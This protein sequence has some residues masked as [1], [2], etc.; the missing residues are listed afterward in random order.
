MELAGYDLIFEL[1]RDTLEQ[2]IHAAPF[3]IDSDG[4]SIH[5][6]LAP[7]FTLHKPIPIG[8]KK[9]NLVMI[10]TSVSLVAISRSDRAVI[11]LSFEKTYAE[12]PGNFEL[13]MLDGSITINVP[14]VATDPEQDSKHPDINRSFIAFDFSQSDINLTLDPVWEQKLVTIL[15]S[16]GAKELKEKFHDY[17]LTNMI[18][19]QGEVKSSFSFVV[20][21]GID[22]SSPLVLT[23][24]PEIMWIDKNTLGIF[25]YLR[26]NASGGDVT[27]KQTS[28]RDLTQFSS[29]AFLLSPKGFRSSVVCPSIHNMAVDQVKGDTFQQFVDVERNKDKNPGPA[30][31]EE[32]DLAK[33]A[34]EKFFQS[35]QGKDIIKGVTPTPCGN[36]G[37]GKRVKMP[38]PFSDTTAH[39]TFLDVTL[40]NDQLNFSFR[41]DAEVSCAKIEVEMTSSTE[42]S[43]D[44]W[45]RLITS[46]LKKGEPSVHTSADPFCMAA[47]NFLLSYFIGPLFSTIFT[48]L[49][50]T[51][52]ENFADALVRN[53]IGEAVNFEVPTPSIGLDSNKYF[54]MQTIHVSEDGIQINGTM[55]WIGSSKGQY[56]E[57]QIEINVNQILNEPSQTKLPEAKIFHFPGTNY[58]CPPQ[59]F[60]YNVSYWN[61]AFKVDIEAR[62]VA[63][64]IKINHF[65]ATLGHSS[66]NDPRPTFTGGSAVEVTAPITNLSGWVAFQD[67]PLEGRVE[68]RDSLPLQV[69][70]NN[71]E[72]W[73]LK[74]NGEDGRFDV[75]LEVVATD[76]S[77]QVFV[78]NQIVP[79]Y[80][81]VITFG[82]DYQTAMDDCKTKYQ[83]WYTVNRFV[84]V[85][86]IPM[87]VPGGDPVELVASNIREAIVKKD[88]GAL[89][90]L[91]KLVT[92]HGEHA[93]NLIISA[94][95]TN[96]V[97]QHINTDMNGGKII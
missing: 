76:A 21:P 60:Q 96:R 84:Q 35:D 18:K 68:R 73:I 37:M 71:E 81:E 11:N 6:T 28:D 9:L 32:N 61:T 41:V 46:G 90:A 33:K 4:G 80:G 58:G 53:K 89:P 7:P 59:N 8:T 75:L 29:A 14:I 63:L 83:L 27:Q 36:G 17:V 88:P 64:P 74:A 72:G 77:G 1:S 70:R 10:V 3:E 13:S 87:W 38:D 22:S 57:P 45:G 24:K 50:V 43:I 79:F 25:G 20:K 82:P 91:E 40:G 65:F 69:M 92:F 26:A 39:V 67:P 44:K 93:S 34:Q 31:K 42:L 49:F 48:H 19:K 95:P 55:P 94:P 51:I 62:D 86:T 52:V 56:F 97:S 30:T 12:L 5:T 66:G 23:E 16:E 47:I 78:A 2:A 54:Q 85:S 15:G